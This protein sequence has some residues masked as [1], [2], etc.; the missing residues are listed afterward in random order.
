MKTTALNY[1]NI[2]ETLYALPLEDKQEIKTLLEHNIADARREE[3][4]HNF[5]KS[6]VEHKS[7]KLKFSGKINEL[8]TML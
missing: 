8:K 7:G 4:E 6:K 5:R 2:I 1:N 3:I